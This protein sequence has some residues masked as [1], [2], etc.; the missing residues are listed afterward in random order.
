M[1]GPLLIKYIISFAEERSAARASGGSPPNVNTGIAVAFGLWFLTISSTV[2]TNQ[3]RSLY[4]HVR[5]IGL[6]ITTVVL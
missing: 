4:V 3:V 6:L 2:C 5:L 1:F